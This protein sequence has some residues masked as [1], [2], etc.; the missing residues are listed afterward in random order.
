MSRLSGALGWIVTA[1]AIAA[2]APA[3]GPGLGAQAAAPA[4]TWTHVTYLSGAS[5]YLE[6]GTRDGVR[7]GTHLEVVRGG[8]VIAELVAAFVS[9]TRTS[10]TVSRSTASVAVGDSVRFTGAPPPKDAAIATGGA[11][12]DSGRPRA[13]SVPS[14]LRGRFGV[15]YLTVDPGAGAG[16]ALAQPAFDVRLDGQHLCSTPMGLVVDVRAQRSMFSTP[17]G[18]LAPATTNLT[19]V[20]QAA[21]QWNTIGSPAHLTLGRQFAT[22]LSTIG[23]F[24]G[25]ALDVDHSRVSYGALA[26]V[27]PEPMQ[28]GFSS[29]VR[30][31]GTY[32]QTH[33]A[34]G[35]SRLWSITLGGV[36]S[37]DL[38]QIDREFGYLRATYTDSHLSVFA[39]QEL[40]INRGW[41]KVQD[42]SSTTPTSTFAIVQLTVTDWLSF[43]GGVDNRRSVRLYRDYINP[44][45]T[46][47]DTFRQ[48]E[49][50]GASLS[51]LG[52]VR[53]SADARTSAGGP[54]GTA[55]SY[56][57][58]ASVTRLTPLQLG[59]HARDTRF[60]G[61]LS[62]GELRSASVEM[63]PWGLLRVEFTGGVRD[64]SNPLDGTP[65]DHLTWTGIDADIGIGS[66]VYLMVS[67][68]RE[69]GALSHNLQSY[70][71]L[72]YRF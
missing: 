34:P 10:C 29:A 38:G 51:F 36:G 50:G 68:S 44:E 61:L 58:S 48:G 57:G 56:T 69:S 5:V 26:G 32:L 46:F 25:A 19:R 28:L 14:R 45:T 7:E 42:G 39:A 22:A 71:A 53:I 21:V 62:S 23:I 6:V 17:S 30:E 15:R 12:S 63:N 2:L 3:G 67:T 11:L 55:D 18:G 41:K 35:E 66:S 60:T 1:A 72:S 24:D 52:R 47:D 70:A 16:S 64:S 37:Y 54:A 13:S 33:N 49:W 20:Y 4:V 43:N 40:D 27:E 65:S 8:A 31:Y 9:S 59:V